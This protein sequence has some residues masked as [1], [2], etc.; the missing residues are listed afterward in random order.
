MR[1]LKPP[2]NRKRTKRVRPYS[3]DGLVRIMREVELPEKRAYRQ[4]AEEIGRFLLKTGQLDLESEYDIMN[5]CTI[6]RARFNFHSHKPYSRRERR[7]MEAYK[8]EWPTF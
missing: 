7:I 4:A 3:V 8:H 1:S 2:R 6:Y 5:Q